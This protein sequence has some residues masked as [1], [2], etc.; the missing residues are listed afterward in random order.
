MEE[1]NNVR[2]KQIASWVKTKYLQNSSTL[3]FYYGVADAIEIASGEYKN[4]IC[5]LKIKNADTSPP[6]KMKTRK[7][8][9]PK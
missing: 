5:T 1:N 7:K 4:K 9:P 3:K 6:S 2:C 8:N